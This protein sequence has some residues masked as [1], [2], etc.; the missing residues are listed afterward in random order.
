LEAVMKESTR[1]DDIRNLSL[2]WGAGM[3][4]GILTLVML[5][6]GNEP[7]VV[8]VVVSPDP[9]PVL[10]EIPEV[11]LEAAPEP[12]VVVERLD[13]GSNR[14]Y[15][16]VVTVRGRE[17][18]GYIR[19]DRNEG[20]WADL[21]D[22]NKAGAREYSRRVRVLRRE[23]PRVRATVARIER[24]RARLER[25]VARAAREAARTTFEFKFDSD[26]IDHDVHVE[27][28]EDD[29]VFVVSGSDAKV[30]IVTSPSVH[31][32]GASGVAVAYAPTGLAESLAV[33]GQSFSGFSGSSQSGIRFGH[34]QSIQALDSRSALFTLKSGEQMELSG[35]ATDLGSSMRAI[36]VEQAD[37]REVELS[38]SD[39][40]VVNFYPA[41]EAA[42]PENFR[43]YGTM[44]TR[45]GAEF[46]GYVTWD[47][48]E[49]YSDDMLDGEERGYDQEIPFGE[50]SSIERYSS[51]SAF[52]T[53]NNGDEMVLDGGQDVNSSNSGISVSDPAL[54]QVK[55]SWDDFESV[56]FHEAETQA[57]YSSFD[58]GQ[59]IFGTVVTADNEEYTGNLV[60]DQDEA[61]TWE[62]LNGSQD[63]VEFHI[64]FSRLASVAPLGAH[65]TLVT[66]KDGR[67]FEI[68]GSNDVD[69]GNRGIVVQGGDDGNRLIDWDDVREV[70]FQER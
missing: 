34:I 2:V 20:S 7:Q 35:T 10:V 45:S 32:T 47:V 26:D 17:Y 41:P 52:V 53:L 36:I 27:A 4:A 8:E 57:S 1:R 12:V 13:S 51:R 9:V 23:A 3:T 15:G 5:L 42:R 33:F 24:D 66:L 54:G 19:W 31:V 43:M 30:R 56:R 21:L 60:W 28:D 61:F 64:E 6:R 70:R 44:S 18:E 39:L 16:T 11:A 22:A 68:G 48:D 38:W 59:K 29:G 62:M 65:E 25:E 46:T 50:I 14:L 40:D 63:G 69:S 58:G 49:I 37:G 55:V 67:T